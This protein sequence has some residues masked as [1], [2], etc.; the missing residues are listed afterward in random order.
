MSDTT[1]SA[2]N[3]A[4][5]TGPTTIRTVDGRNVPSAGTW[6]VD[7]SHS[8]VGFIA[9]HLM[10][11]KVRGTFT[12]YSV[13]LTIADRPEESSVV[14]AIQATSIS[15]GDPARDGHV[16][17]PD[18]LDAEGFPTIDFRSTAV[19]PSG[20]TWSVTGDLTVHG[21]TKPVVL[22]VEFGG[23][24]TDPWGASRAFF[25]A[26]TEFDREDFGITFNQPLAGGGVLVGK[27]VKI[28]LEISAVAA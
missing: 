16:I 18:F 9:R 19:V 28:E 11:T 24:A 8:T 4:A 14:V 7:T 12:D 6:N 10:V 25:S 5:T 3:T 22:D 20:D 23:V 1:I 13:D 21:V 2:T 15:T 27:I 26:T 17:S